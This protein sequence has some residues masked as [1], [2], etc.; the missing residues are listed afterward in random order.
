[1][2]R[3]CY[4]LTNLPHGVNHD[5]SAFVSKE[6]GE[7]GGGVAGPLRFHRRHKVDEL[8]V[9]LVAKFPSLGCPAVDNLA[10]FG[11]FVELAGV[12]V[13]IGLEEFVEEG[14]VEIGVDVGLR[15]QRVILRGVVAIGIVLRVR[16]VSVR[17]GQGGVRGGRRVVVAAAHS[18]RDGGWLGWWEMKAPKIASG[19]SKSFLVRW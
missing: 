1:M 7:Y 11:G 6:V 5:E 17:C 15:G 18:L 19:I 14:S 12:D 13:G 16:R 8:L 3:L 2:I 9:D 10:L 4:N